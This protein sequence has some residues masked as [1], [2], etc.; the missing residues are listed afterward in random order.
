MKIREQTFK[1]HQNTRLII[2]NVRRLFRVQ[3]IRQGRY[4][5]TVKKPN[6]VLIIDEVFHTLS[7]FL[8]MERWIQLTIIGS[9]SA[10]ETNCL[11]I[12]FVLVR[13]NICCSIIDTNTNVFFVSLILPDAKNKHQEMS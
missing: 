9:P 7:K 5:K 2:L 11:I 6:K 13:E 3:K 1:T 8:S 12:S 4:F 10:F